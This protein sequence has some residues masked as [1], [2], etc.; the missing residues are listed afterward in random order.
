MKI[1]SMPIEIWELTC[2][3][4]FGLYPLWALESCEGL[5]LVNCCYTSQ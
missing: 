4:Q 5:L 2:V 3:R 1:E